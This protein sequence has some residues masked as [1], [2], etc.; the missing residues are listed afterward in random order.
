MRHLNSSIDGSNLVNGFDF[1]TQSSMN[2]EDF[3][4]DDGSDGK[5]VE[6]LS[7]VFPGIRVSILSVDFVVKTI[8]SGDLS[9]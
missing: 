1:W 3:S 9:T 7:T 4:V 2:T 8:N 6:D 5:V